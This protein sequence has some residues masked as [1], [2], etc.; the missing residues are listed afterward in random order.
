MQLSERPLFE[1]HLDRLAGHQGV[2]RHEMLAEPALGHANAGA[3][4]LG[5][6]F[7][8]FGR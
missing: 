4:M 2:A 1:I 7:Q 3:H 8:D 6:A 5:G